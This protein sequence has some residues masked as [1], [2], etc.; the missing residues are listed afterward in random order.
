MII[1]APQLKA[2]RRHAQRVGEQIGNILDNGHDGGDGDVVER[3]LNSWAAFVGQ[4]GDPAAGDTV[5]I[6]YI[7]EG[8][9]AG[10][11]G[12][13]PRLHLALTHTVHKL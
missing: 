9:R 10:V 11:S 3:L 1:K 5:A 13:N 12:V 7:A 4:F 6:S 2:A 8:F